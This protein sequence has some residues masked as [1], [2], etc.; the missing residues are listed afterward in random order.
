MTNDVSNTRALRDAFGAFA[1]GV[2][3]VAASTAEGRPIGFT[4]N[5]F[6]S[7]SLDPPM[8]LICLARSSRNFA[9]MMAADN[10]S[11]SVLSKAQREVSDIFARPSEDR[12]ARVDWRRGGNGAPVIGGAAAWFE[13]DASQ[14]VEAG[15]HVVILGR[16]TAFGNTGDDG[17]GYVR[18]GYFVPPRAKPA[19]KPLLS[20][21]VERDRAVFLLGEETRALPVFEAAAEDPVHEIAARAEAL[22]GLRIT[23]EG[24]FSVYSS[25]ADGRRHLVYRASASGPGPAAAGRFV[26]LEDIPAC[27]FDTTATRDVMTRYAM[28]RAQGRFGIYFG[29]EAGG[30]ILPVPHPEPTAGAAGKEGGHVL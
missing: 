26:P 25:E 13:C 12:F 3:V 1:T 4:A 2:T 8:L 19:A 23:P 24:L 18:G 5:S 14:R 28:E 15:D 29:T 16:V 17:L 11:V 20:V 6:T 22:I 10:F 21:V 9:T 27:R 7:V 30:E